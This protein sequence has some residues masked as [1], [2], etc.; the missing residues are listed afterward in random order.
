[1]NQ[2]WTFCIFYYNCCFMGVKTI[3]EILYHNICYHKACRACVMLEPRIQYVHFVI[4]A[5]AED[6]TANALASST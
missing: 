6:S 2:Q 5:D 1:M 4:E 3:L